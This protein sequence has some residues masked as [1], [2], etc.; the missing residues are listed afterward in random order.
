M[1]AD[2]ASSACVMY[3][4]LAGVQRTLLDHSEMRSGLAIGNALVT[5]ICVHQPE[6]LGGIPSCHLHCLPTMSKGVGFKG[7]LSAAMPLLR[8]LLQCLM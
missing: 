8:I 3:S 1:P 5:A 6:M 2:M 7:L 4:H